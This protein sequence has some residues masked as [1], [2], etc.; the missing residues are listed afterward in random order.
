MLPCF[1]VGGY[2]CLTRGFS[3]IYLPL[4]GVP[5]LIGELT[6]LTLT[7]VA[8]LRL[9]WRGPASILVPFVLWIGYNAVLTARDLG[10]YGLD[11]VRDAA[12]W[13][14]AGFALIGAATWKELGTDRLRRWMGLVFGVLVLATPLVIVAAADAIPEIE[15]PFADGS[16]LQERFDATA[17]HLIGGATLF[18]TGRGLRRPPWPGW[19]G[20]AL[21]AALLGLA[22]M[23]QVRAA[24]VGLAGAIAALVIYRLVRPVVMIGLALVIVLALMWAL[25]V[26]VPTDRGVVSAGTIVDRQASTILFLLGATEPSDRTGRS[27]VEN[28]HAGTIE[29]RTIWW[30][31]LI[32]ESL[33][34]Q[35]YLLIG[36]GYGLDLREAVTSRAVGTLNWDQ[37]MD[38]GKPVRSPHNIAVTIFARSGLIG[39]GLWLVVI[40]TT[41]TALIRSTLRYR[42]AGDRDEELF[43]AWLIVYVL[44]MVL[45]ALLG[46][47]LE[48]P[49]GAGPFF[50]VV[51]VGLRGRAASARP[52]TGE[53]RA[54]PPG[55][56]TRSARPEQWGHAADTNRDAPD[57][58]PRLG[59]RTGGRARRLRIQSVRDASPG[60]VE[61]VAAASHACPAGP[62]LATWPDDRERCPRPDR[63]VFGGAHARA[64]LWAYASDVGR[65]CRAVGDRSGAGLRL[66]RDRAPEQT[67]HLAGIARHRDPGQR[68]L[69]RLVPT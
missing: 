34:N 21:A 50:W 45:V 29:W 8:M 3:G 31:A 58:S 33:G 47:V 18:L 40:V 49:F 6:L 2:I 63:R 35:T 68:R 37:G 5:L 39:L 7:P 4:G 28:D 62:R 51:G 55:Q 67:D 57:R 69:D 32:E 46:V 53:C 43:G 16:I 27:D 59:A 60:R 52:R 23:L 42:R 24:F 9:G 56:T 19:L 44:A 12:L 30:R 10:P 38:E 1:V 61:P 66:L 25:D 11:T 64:R 20:I 36:R 26:E 14:Y 65:P 22:A 54:S 17:M 13:Y 41:L 48:S 15:V